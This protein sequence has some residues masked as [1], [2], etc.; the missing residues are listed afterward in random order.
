[1]AYQ[2]HYPLN[3]ISQGKTVTV[4]ITG[5]SCDVVLVDSFN[6]SKLK[7]GMSY[8]YLGGHYHSSPVLLTVP[9]SGIWHVVISSNGTFSS[10]VS[11]SS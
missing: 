9:S 2:N 5:H 3:H 11:V 4:K 1:M 7:K 6:F 10:N 8:Q